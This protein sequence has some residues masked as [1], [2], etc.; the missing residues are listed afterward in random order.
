MAGYTPDGQTSTTKEFIYNGTVWQELGGMGVL[1][2]LAYKDEASGEYTPTG[3]NAASAV[4]FGADS[5][6][7]VLKADATF[8]TTKPNVTIN[9][10]NN[11]VQAITAM[12]TATVEKVVAG[13][14]K[15]IKPNKI[16]VPNVT[17][18]GSVGSE[19]VWSATV[20]DEN[21]TIS[22][23]TNTPTTP[24]TLGTAISVVNGINSTSTSETG[25][26]AYI[27]NVT[28]SGT[29]DV[30]FGA[31]TKVSV[32]KDSVTAELEEAPSVTVNDGS[33]IAAVTGNGVAAAQTFTGTKATITVS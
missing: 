28:T 15:Y 26:I 18:A 22:W 17:S 20:Q 8:T 11:T 1:K 6:T 9:K 13:T 5:K 7:N 24:P 14:T 12:P 33:S 27:D 3:S 2:A 19:A 21:L 16:S 30:S 29:S 4:T 32:L 23:T 10:A 25:S 31:P